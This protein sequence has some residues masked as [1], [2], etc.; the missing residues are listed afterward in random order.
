ME[1]YQ[2]KVLKVEEQLKALDDYNIATAAMV[3]L[4]PLPPN[5]VRSLL[6]DQDLLNLTLDLASYGLGIILSGTMDRM[7][8]VSL[9]TPPPTN[10]DRRKLTR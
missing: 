5:Q 2:L 7:R 9:Q 3:L 10:E 6:R 1:E 4:G 8:E